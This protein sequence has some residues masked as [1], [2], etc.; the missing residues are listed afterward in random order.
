MGII[1]WLQTGLAP[2]AVAFQFN[3]LSILIVVKGNGYF[4]MACLEV[5][6]NALAEEGDYAAMNIT[7]P[8]IIHLNN[9]TS[10]MYEYCKLF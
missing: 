2:A 1:F 5:G 10:L 3:S 9:I 7:F 4:C 6:H 8:G